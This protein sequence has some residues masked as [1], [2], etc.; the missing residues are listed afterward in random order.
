MENKENPT[1]AS[2]WFNK[3]K[4]DFENLITEENEYIL[5]N[6]YFSLAQIS[7]LSE[8]TP[9]SIKKTW[10]YVWNNQIS[11][12]SITHVLITRNKKCEIQEILKSTTAKI[13]E[14]L[15][16]III[17][18]CVSFAQA[19]YLEE[20]KLAIPKNISEIPLMYPSAQSI[21]ETKYVTIDFISIARNEIIHRN[22]YTRELLLETA[23]KKLEGNVIV[24][25]VLTKNG[26]KTI[27]ATGPW[28]IENKNDSLEM[29]I[30]TAVRK[31]I[32][33]FAL[34]AKQ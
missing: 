1:T 32:K 12:D 8:I 17:P 25:T 22:I 29:L 30:K 31:S 7:N 18:Q 20:N 13:C 2:G 24:S 14:K 28:N 4:K 33:Y 34:L 23:R 11:L 6:F 27:Q 9:D 10:I 15:Q 3:L 16:A 5:K 21:L 19:K 26:I